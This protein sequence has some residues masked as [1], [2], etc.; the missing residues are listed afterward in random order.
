MFLV[1]NL[2]HRLLGFL[3]PS[4]SLKGVDRLGT[5]QLLLKKEEI[6]DAIMK[7]K[8]AVVFDI[9]LATS[10]AASMFYNGAKEVIPV[11]N[12]EEA[13]KTAKE[14]TT[15]DY[16]LVGEYLGETIAGFHGPI[17]TLLKNVVRGKR[18]IFTT[19]N[20]T[21]ALKNS[22]A[23]D[24]V[25]AASMLNEEAV[26]EHLISKY[27]AKNYVLVCSG[28]SNQFNLEDLYGAGSFIAN[29]VQFGKERGITWEMSDAAIAALYFYNGNRE[30]GE[31]LLKASRVGQ[32]LVNKGYGDEVAYIMQKNA[33]P[34][35][36]KLNGDILT[37]VE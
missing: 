33:C 17:P 3:L 36:P 27:G 22:R 2:C 26:A 9:L 18:V 30:N 5:I 28:S 6:H 1:A 25:Y 11:L 21:V 29:L 31:A 20:G 15:D 10:T 32:N 19:T 14:Q 12:Q 16:I 7:N 8:I 34:V 35:I 37:L 24:A 13:L 23:A 4:I